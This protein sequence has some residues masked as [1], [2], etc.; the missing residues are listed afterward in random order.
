MKNV[1]ERKVGMSKTLIIVE[2]L[3]CLV[4]IASVEAGDQAQWGQ[5][6][7]RNM[8]SDEKGLPDMIDP[9]KGTNIKWKA[10]LG[11]E[12]YATP[13][14]SQGRVFVGTNNRQPRDPAHKG[15]RATLACFNESDGRFLWQLVSPKLTNSIYWDWP[16][17]G[18]C[19]PPTI[20]G[21]NVYV[22][23]NR[24]EVMCLDINGLANGNEGPFQNEAQHLIPAGG[25]KEELTSMDAD[26]LWLFDIIK[27]C[28]IRQ[29]DSA[30]SSI[31]M[32]GPF[33][34]V[35]TSNGVD[36]THRKIA[37]PDAPSLIV[38]EKNTGRLVAQDQERIGP[39]IFHCT[40]SSPA[41]GVVEGHRVIFFCGGDGV[42]YGFE[43]LKEIPKQKESVALKC[44]WKFDCDPDS[45]KENVHRF[46]SNRKESP[47]NIKSMPVFDQGRL[48]V[49]SGGDLWWGKNETRL[50]CI[51]TAGQGDVTKTALV[52][53]YPL[54]RHS[55]S[56]PA[57]RNGLVY[58]ADC[59]GFV[60]CVDAET[61]KMVWKQDVKGE[62]WASAMV[63]DGKV[64]I[65]TRDGQFLIF[66]EGREKQILCDVDLDSPI[67][68]TATAANGTVYVA[69]MKMLY[70][71]AV[72]SSK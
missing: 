15:E 4:G 61:G 45:P 58:A 60:H 65:G 67:A 64:Y 41:L 38:V 47:S 32:D 51:K 54:Q 36:D 5:V 30:H 63:A 10:A 22:V 16:G 35:N 66:K 25:A 3:L 48:Y 68:G 24:G 59:G 71:L 2:V 26:I 69:T 46:T 19:S 43:A 55:M 49:T 13:I 11:T 31:L 17:A 62:V 29:H 6:F 20:E 21:T 52:W 39:R 37:S 56:T 12:T 18:I 50:Q 8:V 14:V 1:A 27:E 42:V 9:E 33:L 28:G 57:V 7:S 70:A 72:P 40:W 44:I 53:S 23:G 34:Y